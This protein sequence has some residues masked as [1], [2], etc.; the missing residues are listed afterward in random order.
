MEIYKEMFKLL[1]T[2]TIISSYFVNL[3]IMYFC[4]LKDL[5][6]ANIICLVFVNI[7]VLAV[8]FLID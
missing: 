4:D 1:N 2:L 3:F 7:I 8:A 6:I 5:L